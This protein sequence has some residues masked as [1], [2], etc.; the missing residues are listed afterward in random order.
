MIQRVFLPAGAEG[1]VTPLLI[2]QALRAFVDGYVTILLPAYLL[3][4]AK[5]APW[6]R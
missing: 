5:F 3:A 4:C 6:S 1:T 2:E